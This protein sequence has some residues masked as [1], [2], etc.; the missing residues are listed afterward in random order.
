MAGFLKVYD[1]RRE[2]PGYV[3]PAAVRVHRLEPESAPAL[4]TLVLF[5]RDTSGSESLGIG[6]AALYLR[7]ASPTDLQTAG[8]ADVLFALGT[9]ADRLA[10]RA[11]TRMGP[12]NAA[13]D[14]ALAGQLGVAESYG[15][16]L[17]SS[18]QGGKTRLC[19]DGDAYARVLSLPSRPGRARPR[20]ARPHTPALRHAP[21]GPRRGARVERGPPARP[22][23]CRP[24]TRPRKT[25]SLPPGSPIACAAASPRRTPPPSTSRPAAVTSRPPLAPR[26]P[27]ARAL[28]LVDRGQLAPEDRPTYERAALAGRRGPLGHHAHP[29]GPAALA[30]E[31]RAAPHGP[32]LPAHPQQEERD[33]RRAVHV[34]APLGRDRSSGR[35][36]RRP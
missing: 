1:H 33:D 23:R 6:Y 26:S 13:T 17:A 2:R 21:R 36:G 35:R 24:R 11:S 19:Y 12:R 15:I 28:A 5:L 18:D 16:K 14:A 34:R 31:V 29:R 20:R 22:R 30:A 3:R 25:A 7:A 10:R 32:E 9:M 27:A 4:R 8:A